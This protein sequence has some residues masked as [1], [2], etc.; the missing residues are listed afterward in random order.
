MKIL[1]IFLSCSLIA[2]LWFHQ[3]LCQ[4]V[5]A[6][7]EID[8]RVMDSPPETGWSTKFRPAVSPP[9]KPPDYS[10]PAHLSPGS[11]PF[12]PSNSPIQNNN[13]RTKEKEILS[14]SI[15]PEVTGNV[16]PHI[17]Q[18][19]PVPEPSIIFYQPIESGFG[20]KPSLA[21]RLTARQL[22][23]TNPDSKIISTSF[24]SS[25]ENTIT[26]LVENTTPFGLEVKSLALDAGQLLLSFSK[27][28]NTR[29]AVIALKEDTSNPGAIILKAKI[30]PYGN[31]S[32]TS[33]LNLFLGRVKNSIESKDIL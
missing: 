25:L 5:M 13:P 11:A 30:L 28:D 8:D 6:T 31:Q 14:I 15:P 1:S 21:W 29:Y 10:R 4:P 27:S 20:N 17:P 32:T 12:K 22:F 26:A 2:A 24:T 16:L 33:I 18:A 19:F 9:L 7:A 3:S 23:Q